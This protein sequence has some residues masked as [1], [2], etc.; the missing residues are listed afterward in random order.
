MTTYLKC[1]RCNREIKQSEGFKI[2]IVPSQGKGLITD[3]DFCS[4]CKNK[5]EVWRKQKK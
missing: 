2:S 3:Y 5:F 4:A 1:D